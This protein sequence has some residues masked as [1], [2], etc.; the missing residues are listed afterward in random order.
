[1]DKYTYV[2]LSN[3]KPG[4]E[5]AYNQWYTEQHLEDVLAIPGFTAAQRFKV[6]DESADIAHRYLALYEVESD[7]IDETMQQLVDRA[8]DGRMVMTDAMDFDSVSAT[9]YK[10]ITPKVTA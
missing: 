1:M 5:E 10:A 7:N 8:G 6:T 3:P 9:L 2:V 4:Q